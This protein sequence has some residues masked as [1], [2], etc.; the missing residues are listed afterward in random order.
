MASNLS[1]DAWVRQ[2]F[3][4]RYLKSEYRNVLIHS[5]IIEG[6]LRNESR[7]NKFASANKALLDSGKINCEEFR[8]FDQIREIRNSLVHE[9]FKDRLVQKQIDGLRDELMKKILEAY[10]ISRFLNYA[11]FM[12]YGLVR[13]PSVAFDPASD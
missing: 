3:A 2:Q 10:R 13:V 5:S 4:K 9:S 12:K 6:T 11:L 7:R 1:H 8:V